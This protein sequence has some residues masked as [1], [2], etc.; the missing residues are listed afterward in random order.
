MIKK[1][2]KW[3]NPL[4][5]RIISLDCL[6][7]HQLFRITGIY[8]R[9]AA[10]TRN[11]LLDSSQE[12]RQRVA[13][14]AFAP[15]AYIDPHLCKSVVHYASTRD[16][17]LRL[18]RAGKRRCKDTIIMLQPHPDAAWHDHEFISSTFTTKQMKEFKEY[19]AR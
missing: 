4:K 15:G 7:Y 10:Y 16:A 9:G 19:M 8:V 3:D 17:V 5:R 18:D 13:V 12:Q 6:F 11:A 14:C 1:A 2:V